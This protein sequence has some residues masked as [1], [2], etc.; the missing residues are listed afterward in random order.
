MSTDEAQLQSPIRRVYL[1]GEPEN[2]G[3]IVHQKSTE[4]TVGSHTADSAA[5]E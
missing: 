4:P 3:A 1:T 2:A 5:C